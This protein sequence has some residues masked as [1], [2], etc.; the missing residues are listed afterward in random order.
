MPPS[1]TVSTSSRF[2][3]PAA[4]TP[5]AVPGRARAPQRRRARRPRPARPAASAPSASAGSRP[6][7]RSSASWLAYAS[8]QPRAPHRHARAVGRI[9]TWP[10]SPPKPRAPRNSRPSSTMPGAD[11]DLAGD[12]EEARPAV[13]RPGVQLAERGQV[14]L[15]VDGD[16]A[17]RSP[18]EPAPV[19][20]PAT[21]TSR[22]PRF[23]ASR[24]TAVG[25]QAR[26]RPARR[27][28]TRSPSAAAA[29]DRVAGR[30]RPGR[31]APSAGG[32]PRWS[33]WRDL[34]VP[35]RRR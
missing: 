27:R 19:S 34:A 10:S 22:Q 15:V 4:A 18:A 26:A 12:V 6:A 29:R 35:A 25:D 33:P 17:R 2:T 21:S 14:G 16:S 1:T 24:T 9:V 32:R 28:P 30:A 8:R 31:R 11:A 23:G 3:T 7:A 5:S 20:A 13:A